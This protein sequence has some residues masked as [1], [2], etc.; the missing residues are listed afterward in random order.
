MNSS[1]SDKLVSIIIPSRD[2]IRGGAVPRLVEA[3]NRQ[4]Y[5]NRECIVVKG[6]S[7]QGRAINEGV[8]QSAGELLVIMDDDAFPAA[9]DIIERLV[10]AVEDR[11]GIG[12]AGAS[13]IISDQSSPFQRR[14]AEQFPRFN[15]P[16]VD[17]IMKS[18]MACHGCCLIPR[19]VFEE[20]GGERED[21]IRGLD[22]DLRSRIRAAGYDVVLVPST[23]VYHPLPE[24][25][26]ALLR[27]F[28][29]NGF[30]SSYT[31][32]Y[33]PEC[34]IETHED[35]DDGTFRER[36][37]FPYRIARFPV[38]LVNALAR[39]QWLRFSAYCSYAAG[40]VWG[41]FTADKQA[42]ERGI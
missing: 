27:L 21:I 36:R 18:D 25:Y 34:V 16:V 10:N 38:R 7:P 6:V 19:A 31:R 20:V 5:A 13:I 40:Y 8:S 1:G 42:I 14:A 9:D 33:H 2:G 29:R 28:F 41:T 3:L 23:A 30:G 24:T 22:P 39:G 37:S 15:T 11:N 26:A 12:M 4:T 35:V 17:S 32:K